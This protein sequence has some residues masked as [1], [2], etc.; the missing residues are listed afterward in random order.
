MVPGD[1][2]FLAGK[3]II[4]YSKWRTRLADPEKV[5]VIGIGDDGLEGMTASTHGLIDEADVL[6]GSEKSLSLIPQADAERIQI[7]NDLSVLPGYV[8]R[9]ENRKVVVR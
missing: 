4:W 8:S 9:N 3:A 7:G 1:R 6:I 5:H 2:L